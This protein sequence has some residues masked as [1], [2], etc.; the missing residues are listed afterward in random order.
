MLWDN[1]VNNNRY[2]FMFQNSKVSPYGEVLI[3]VLRPY[4]EIKK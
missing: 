3:G 1:C 2:I 4:A